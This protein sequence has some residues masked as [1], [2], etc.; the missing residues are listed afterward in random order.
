M[1]PPLPSDYRISKQY[2][3]VDARKP[4]TQPRRIQV[5]HDPVSENAV[6]IGLRLQEILGTG[7]A[8]E[9]LKKN[10]IDINVTLRVLLHPSRR[11]AQG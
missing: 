9:F 7:D 3:P 8:A 11:R 1:Q 10:M 2:V 6:E 5:R 4:R